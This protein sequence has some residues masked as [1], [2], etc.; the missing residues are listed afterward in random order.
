MGEAVNA[1]FDQ[2]VSVDT[3]SIPWVPSPAKGVWRRKLDRV[4]AESGWTTSLVRYEAGHQFPGHLHPGGEEFLVLD[5]V[6]SDEQGDYPA[7]TYVRNPPGS[8][9][10][11]YTRDGCVIF[12]KLHQFLPGDM[13]R[14]RLNTQQGAWKTG[15]VPGLELL[16]LHRYGSEL[17]NLVRWAPGVSLSEHVHPGG[18]EM[19]VLSG[20]ISDECGEYPAG[21]WLRLPRLSRHEPK[22]GPEGAL[23]LLKVGHLP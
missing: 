20:A 7:G 18:E 11:P 1:D 8:S 2:R 6:F 10:A 13:K 23:I 3:E 15:R 9:H 19:L 17:V 16:E 14:V 4:A 21:T 12:V 22:A 5:G